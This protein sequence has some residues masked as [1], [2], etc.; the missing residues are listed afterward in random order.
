MLLF[1][2]IYNC[3]KCGL[4]IDKDINAKI[5][6]I[7]RATIGQMESHAQGDSVSPQK[8]AGIKEL[9]TGKTHPL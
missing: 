7:N 2:R 5:N 6:I 8:E 1:E 9:R 3:N 4:Q